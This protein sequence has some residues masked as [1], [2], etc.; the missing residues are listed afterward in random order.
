MVT[1]YFLLIADKDS[2]SSMFDFNLKPRTM[3]AFI[4][5]NGNENLS[6]K[7]FADDNN[8]NVNIILDIINIKVHAHPLCE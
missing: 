2:V 1:R 7:S 5:D 3:L 8:G 6:D 4:R